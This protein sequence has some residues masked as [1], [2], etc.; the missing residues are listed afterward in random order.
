MVNQLKLVHANTHRTSLLSPSAVA[1]FSS[2]DE[3]DWSS[4]GRM[5]F[6]RANLVLHLVAEDPLRIWVGLAQFLRMAQPAL[7]YEETVH[8]LSA[9]HQLA[10]MQHP[11]IWL[12]E[13]CAILWLV[14][15]SVR[16]VLVRAGVL[17][18]LCGLGMNALVT[19]A[20]AGSMPVVGMPSSI[21]PASPLWQV[22]TPHTR[23]SV[24]ADQA[25]LGLFSVGDV[26]L[27]F[28]GT[29]I[30]V[31]CIRRTLTRTTARR[32]N[33]LPSMERGDFRGPHSR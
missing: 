9:A 16:S 32:A 6:F 4:P 5:L 14:V 27:L 22:A 8:F 21:R 20:N 24:L 12:F 28:G 25:R 19:D 18:M 10:W 26:S 30:V 31:I 23:L 2:R 29:L 7:A 15:R 33:R 17:L 11:A 3:E 13:C 1:A